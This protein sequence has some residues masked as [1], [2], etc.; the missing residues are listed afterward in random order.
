MEKKVEFKHCKNLLSVVG[1]AVKEGQKLSGVEVSPQLFRQGGLLDWLSELG[2]QIKD[3]GDITKE[4]LH[5]EIQ[6][7]LEGN[8]NTYKYKIENAEIIGVLNRK[9]HDLCHEE[10][11]K[12]RFMLNLGGDH[13]MASGT[14]TGSLRTY[15]DLRVIWFDAHGDCNTPETS[16]SGN[17]HGMPMAHC[18]GWIKKNDIKSFDWLDIHVKAENVVYIGLRDLDAGEKS[19]LAKYNVKYYTP[20]DIDDMGGIKHVM[21]EALAYLKCDKDS[22]NPVHI[23]W[24]VD[25]CDPSFIYGTGTKAR[26]GLSERE[27]HYLLQRVAGTGN[28][29]SLDMVEV[30]SYLDQVKERE[31]YHGDHHKIKGSQAICSAIELTVS[32]L[33]FSWR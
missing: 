6:N 32:A 1:V 11:K 22:N 5:G 17:Y 3:L 28:L 14:I 19:L 4:D 15:P 23:S 13:G 2:W 26:A 12:G 29:V 9:L 16:P 20:Y 31:H 27:S 33:G 21:D 8:T 30:N 10:T 18:F 7:E 25:G 24:D